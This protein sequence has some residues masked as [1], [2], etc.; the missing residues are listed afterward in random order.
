[1]NVANLYREIKQIL[2]DSNIALADKGLS[3]INNLREIPNEIAKLNSI[4]YLPYY[5]ATEF[6]EISEENIG[7][8]TII[9]CFVNF[10][11]LKSVTIPDS[12][13]SIDGNTFNYCTSLTEITIPDSV[14]TIDVAAFYGCTSLTEITIPDSVTSIEMNVFGNCS[15]LIDIYLNPIIPPVLGGTNAIPDHT[16]IH[17]PIGS[18]DAYKSATNWSYHSSRIVEDIELEW[19]Q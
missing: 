18:G 7:R 16:T 5:F 9:R 6:I 19:R 4:N 10:K 8:P 11:N 15:S 14:T 1:M 13:T 12:V 17:V 2:N 3:E